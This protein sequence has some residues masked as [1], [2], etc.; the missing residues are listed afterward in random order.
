MT[1]AAPSIAVAERASDLK[2]IDV[3]LLRALVQRLPPGQSVVRLLNEQLAKAVRRTPRTVQSALRR[4]VKAGLVTREDHTSKGKSIAIGTE[5]TWPLHHASQCQCSPSQVIESLAATVASTMRRPTRARRRRPLDPTKATERF[6][7]RCLREAHRIAHLP[8][9]VASAQQDCETF[10]EFLARGFGDRGPVVEVHLLGL[11]RKVRDGL[12]GAPSPEFDMPLVGDWQAPRRWASH[13]RHCMAD[14][15]NIAE[16][17]FKIQDKDHPLLLVDD[18]CEEALVRIPAGSAVVET[19]PGCFQVSAFAPR[20]LKP[21]ERLFAQRAL[22][23]LLSGDGAANSSNQLRRMPGSVNNRDDLDCAFVARLASV[24]RAAHFDDLTLQHLLNEG[25]V[26]YMGGSSALPQ[27]PDSSGAAPSSP[28]ER[29]ASRDTTQSGRDIRKVMRR[30]ANGEPESEVR[31]DLE[32]SA[33]SRG[34]SRSAATGNRGYTGATL[35]KAKKY[36]AE[37]GVLP[38]PAAA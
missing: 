31:R 36:L 15:M 9:A 13:L 33:I 32:L 6:P 35:A 4:L 3:A 14:A 7:Y 8:D 23:E 10:V 21:Q 28:G 24:D 22:I 34:K 27:T 25:Y 5:V 2:P 38:R 12:R 26:L 30:L 20:N 37:R 19:S 29:S 17:M 16:A 1:H 11:R 18:V